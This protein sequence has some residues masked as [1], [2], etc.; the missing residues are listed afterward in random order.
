[1]PIA[2]NSISIIIPVLNE[3]ENVKGLLAYLIEKQAGGYISEI[4]VVDGH[5]QDNTV[6]LIQEFSITASI[7]IKIIVSKR[8]RAK[9]MNAGANLS[10]SS[11][12]YFLH[13]DSY[14]PKGFDTCIISE[15]KKQQPSR[16][17]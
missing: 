16:M 3:A 8:G 7:D 11:I 13:A 12:L 10:K 4:I 5:S 6:A 2:A 17:F 15:I 14:P 1:M 9:Q